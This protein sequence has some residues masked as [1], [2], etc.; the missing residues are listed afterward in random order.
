MPNPIF[1]T[2]TDGFPQL[3]LDLQLCFPLY[4]V[5]RAITTRYGHL[6]GEV[7]LTYPQYL[8]MLALWEARTMTVGELGERLRLDSG[9][10]SPLLKRLQATG[11]VDR[12][13][14]PDDERRVQVQPTEAG[15][16]LR[17]RVA[18]VPA[19]IAAAMG[20]EPE[21]YF[22]LKRRL[23]DMLCSLDLNPD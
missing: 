9:T 5:S 21:A 6:L 11:L 14:D 7:G 22:D 20:L 19:G 10:L 13:R 1:P 8:V 12:R 17:E 16:D 23:A 2:P 15:W 18:H 4:A 3:D